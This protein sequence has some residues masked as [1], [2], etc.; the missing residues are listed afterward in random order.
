MKKKLIAVLLAVAIVCTMIVG[1]ASAA[2][3]NGYKTLNGI[4]C[5]GTLTWSGKYASASSSFGVSGDGNY[6]DT[7]TTT[8]TT[9]YMVNGVEMSTSNRNPAVNSKGNSITAPYSVTATTT[10]AASSHVFVDN[11]VTQSIYLSNLY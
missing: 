9:Y 5:R 1:T 11:G 4:A 8:A 2:P 7:L 10:R 6:A 3:V